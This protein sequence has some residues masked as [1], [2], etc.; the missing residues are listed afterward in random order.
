M[1]L[2]VGAPD[3]GFSNIDGTSIG[4]VWTFDCVDSFYIDVTLQDSFGAKQTTAITFQNNVFVYNITVPHHW[5]NMI[6][7]PFYWLNQSIYI[8]SSSLNGLL[9]NATA[10]SSIALVPAVCIT[11]CI[12]STQEANYSINVYRSGASIELFVANS[13]FPYVI[14]SAPLT[15]TSLTAGLYNYSYISRIQIS[16]CLCQRCV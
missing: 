13:F 8:Q 9:S 14:L 5:I 15:P 11:V 10:S 4:A 16:T 3:D 12:T 1:T 2:V 6:I 7:T